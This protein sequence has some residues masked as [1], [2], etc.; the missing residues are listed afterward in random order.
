MLSSI[1]LPESSS[2][3]RTELERALESE[4]VKEHEVFAERIAILLHS[5]E[6]DAHIKAMVDRLIESCQRYDYYVMQTD[7]HT[8]AQQ[9]DLMEPQAFRDMVKE[10]DRNR[11][12]THEAVTLAIRS[13]DR[14]CKQQEIPLIFGDDYEDR[15]ATAHFAKSLSREC[16]E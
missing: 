5:V 3:R 4:K 11:R 8:L 6:G 12:I 2:A 13:L 1:T 15:Y 7:V 14:I 16:L 10:L 9:T